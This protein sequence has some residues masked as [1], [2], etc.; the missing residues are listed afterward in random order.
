[1]IRREVPL[2]DEPAN[3]L[4]ISQV[5]HARISGELAAAWRAAPSP[6]A[7]RNELLAASTHHD[8]GWAAA[9]AH[10]PLDPAQGR[11]YSFLDLPRDD[12]LVLWRDSILIARRI[13]PLAGWSVAGHFVRLLVDS[14]HAKRETSRAW[15]TE[16]SRWR[17]SWLNEWTAIDRSIN[18]VRL[19]GECLESVRLFDWLSLWL[20]CQCPARPDD[21]AIAPAMSVDGLGSA[22][23]R[24]ESESDQAKGEPRTVL[25]SPWPFVGPKVDVDA[26]GYAVPVQ[27]YATSEELAKRRSPLRL[28]WR[29][30]EGFSR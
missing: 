17:Q 25:V 22:P 10:P 29:L 18:T 3:W 19:A 26:L 14:E 20:C 12:S 11:P 28:R 15:L 30:V 2:T 5:E 9:E 8:D 23:V 13:G 7:V 21:D 24:F 1:M 16:V 4:L 27:E 6:P